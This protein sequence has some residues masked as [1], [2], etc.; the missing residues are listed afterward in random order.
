MHKKPFIIIELNAF[1]S[2]RN[3][4]IVY[5]P[6]YSPVRRA[7]ECCCAVCGGCDVGCV[8]VA[9]ELNPCELVFGYVKNSLRRTRDSARSFYNEVFDR[10]AEITPDMLL[11]MYAH[12]LRE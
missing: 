9:Q 4:A 12:C 7:V 2:R 11:R 1:L 8:A 10:F 6:T 5:L 3:I